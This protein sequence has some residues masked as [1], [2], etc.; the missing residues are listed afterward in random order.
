MCKF[1]TE[2]HVYKQH[3][4]DARNIGILKETLKIVQPSLS[5]VLQIHT[6]V[7][8][9]YQVNKLLRKSNSLGKLNIVEEVVS[10]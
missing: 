9:A 5:V 7:C 10:I 2:L 1:R 8:W 4:Q 3:L 6:L